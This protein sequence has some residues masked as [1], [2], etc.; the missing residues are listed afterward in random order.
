MKTSNASPT[1]RN[2]ERTILIVGAMQFLFSEQARTSSRVGWWGAI[3]EENGREI[4]PGGPG[5][6][7]HVFVKSNLGRAGKIAALAS[8]WGA[9]CV[10]FK[11]ES[12]LFP[13]FS[14]L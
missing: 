3:E 10:M 4:T 8:T 6:L 2:L 12:E 9:E 7:S 14:E 13:Q 11:E 5:Q 1:V